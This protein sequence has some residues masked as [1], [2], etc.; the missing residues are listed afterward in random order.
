MEYHLIKNVLTKDQRKYMI[1]E[2]IPL[3]KSFK[4][5]GDRRYPGKQTRETLYLNPKFKPFINRML[6]LI[7]KRTGLVLEVSKSWVN[8][9]NGNKKDIAWHSHSCDYALVYYMRTPLPFFS[10]GTLFREGLI[11]APQNSL[12]LFP[13][14]LEHTAPTSPFRFDRYTMAMDLN[15]RNDND[16]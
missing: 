10:N 8:W 16:G 6:E 1:K 13:S 11:K 7:Y 12:I 4:V 2:S 15:I 9:T 3:L 14:H 5:Q